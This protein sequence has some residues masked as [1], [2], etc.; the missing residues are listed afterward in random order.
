[1]FCPTP[2]LSP[3]RNHA[4][5]VQLGSTL[6]AFNECSTVLYGAASATAVCDVDTGDTGVIRFEDETCTE[7][8]SED[9]D[10]PSCQGVDSSSDEDCSYNGGACSSTTEC[11]DDGENEGRTSM[12]RAYYDRTRTRIAP[13]W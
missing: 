6:V 8:I 10:S 9:V 11:T 4:Y 2:S 7:V 5:A 1:M 12:K 13:P 3:R